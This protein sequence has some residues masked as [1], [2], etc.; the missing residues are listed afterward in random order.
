MIYVFGLFVYSMKAVIVYHKVSR[1][2]G[3]CRVA[4]EDRGG[5]VRVG[6]EG[7]WTRGLVGIR[8]EV[9]LAGTGI[10]HGWMHVEE[11]MGSLFHIAGTGSEPGGV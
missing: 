8:V 7:C 10:K 4:G 2:D 11:V 5:R 6:G 3:Y 1:V 9:K